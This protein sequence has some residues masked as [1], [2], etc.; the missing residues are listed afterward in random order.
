VNRLKFQAPG[1]VDVSRLLK[2]VVHDRASLPAS[3]LVPFG[4]FQVAFPTRMQVIV[5]KRLGKRWSKA[6]VLVADDEIKEVAEKRGVLNRCGE[7][8]LSSDRRVTIPHQYPKVFS[9]RLKTLSNKTGNTNCGSRVSRSKKVG[10]LDRVA[11]LLFTTAPKQ[12][13]GNRPALS[14]L[15]GSGGDVGAVLGD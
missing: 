8:G 7:D 15:E 4:H 9:H 11:K 6:A 14:Q 5:P 2:Y 10:A 13:C 1:V 3:R 12:E